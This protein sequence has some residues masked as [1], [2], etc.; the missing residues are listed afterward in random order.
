MRS[1][2][3]RYEKTG[4]AKFVSHLDLVR[5]FSRA[6]RR[7]G[8]KVYYSEG[9]NPHIKIQF[10]PPLSLG[11]ESLCEAFDIKVTDDTSDKQIVDALCRVLP[12]TL[13]VTNAYEPQNT[14]SDIASVLYGITF[15]GDIDKAVTLLKGEGLF[16]QKKTKRGQISVDVAAT[17][18]SA[19]NVNGELYVTLPMCEGSLNPR[20]VIEA[21]NTYGNMNIEDFGCVRRELFD[22][23]GKVFF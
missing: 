20:H 22:K 10:L 18:L 6:I 3:V 12:A 8:F 23:D 5:A 16:I 17:L 9:F 15:E 21:L 13:R 14:F 2:R 4:D 7:A 1:V 19:E 11:Y